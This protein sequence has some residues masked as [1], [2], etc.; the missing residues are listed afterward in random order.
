MADT[1]TKGIFRE[2]KQEAPQH[3]IIPFVVGFFFELGFSIFY[4][5]LLHEILNTFE[6]L[7]PIH[8]KIEQWHHA[9]AYIIIILTIRILVIGCAV[10]LAYIWIMRRRINEEGKFAF[11]Q[12]NVNYLNQYLKDAES[13]FAVSVTDL[14]KWFIPS[15][16]KY[17]LQLNDYKDKIKFERILLFLRKDQMDYAQDHFIGKDAA[18][19][20]DSWHSASKI[21]LAFLQSHDVRNLLNSLE[22]TTRKYFHFGS[23]KKFQLYINRRK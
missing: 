1:R 5:I 4:D 2:F 16:I 11:N 14:R 13:Y 15:S 7:H 6:Y 22:E 23:I 8:E 21:R 20:F 10:L 9:S 3:F 17:F 12:A 18:E 19:L